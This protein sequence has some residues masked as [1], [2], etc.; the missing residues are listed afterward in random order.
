MC[1]RAEQELF[2]ASTL[3]PHKADL[4]NKLTCVLWAFKSRSQWT[5]HI[6]WYCF[7]SCSSLCY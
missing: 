1:V 5:V 6:K 2:I 7:L 4:T 3:F